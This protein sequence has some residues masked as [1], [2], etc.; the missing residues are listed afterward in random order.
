M[1]SEMAV[2]NIG[3]KMER[4]YFGFKKVVVIKAIV[5]GAMVVLIVILVSYFWSLVFT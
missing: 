3:H 4:T 1:V 2:I 5:T